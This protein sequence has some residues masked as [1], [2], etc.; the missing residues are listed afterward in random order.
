MWNLTPVQIVDLNICNGISHTFAAAAVVVHT[1]S[2][3]DCEGF[4]DTMPPRS[5]PRTLREE[6]EHGCRRQITSRC[7]VFAETLLLESIAESRRALQACPIHM[8][9][10]S[11]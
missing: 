9:I 7:S 11:S 5:I 10:L 8:Y 2:L 6:L 3:V 4:G 1:A